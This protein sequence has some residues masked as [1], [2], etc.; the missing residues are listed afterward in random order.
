M[1]PRPNDKFILFLMRILS[2]SFSFSSM[3]TEATLYSRL[4]GE[5]KPCGVVSEF[6]GCLKATLMFAL[7]GPGVF[8]SEVGS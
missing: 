7:D 2:A 3:H 5:G 8:K 6:L 1:L 4:Q